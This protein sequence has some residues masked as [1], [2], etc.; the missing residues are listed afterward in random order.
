MI[1]TD[2][3]IE[4]WRGTAGEGAE[5]PAVEGAE[6]WPGDPP[7]ENDHLLAEQ[8][9][10]GHERGPWRGEGNDKVQDE[11]QQGDHGGTGL[12]RAEVS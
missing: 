5:E 6:A 3:R 1:A 9:I 8:E 2:C 12:P 4:F 10:L 11:A 7:P